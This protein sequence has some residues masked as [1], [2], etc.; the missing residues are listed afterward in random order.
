MNE[1]RVVAEGNVSVSPAGVT[2][3]CDRIDFSQKTRIGIAEGHVV[4]T[5]GKERM[6]G[7]KM[8]FDFAK[9]Q[10]DFLEA[11]MY[12]APFFGA[13]RKVAKVGDNHLVMEKGYLTTCDLDKPHFGFFSRKIDVF[14][15]DKAVARGTILRLGKVPPFSSRNSAR[16]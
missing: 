6:A 12:A 10:G 14:P 2:L 3:T 1:D 11:K 13:G 4:L 9:M 5:R 7:D 15:G 16:A 8:N